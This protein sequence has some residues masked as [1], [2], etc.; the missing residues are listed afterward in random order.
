MFTLTLVPLTETFYSQRMFDPTLGSSGYLCLQR[1]FTPALCSLGSLS[2]DF[3]F[4]ESVHSH[5]R[6]SGR[7]I[8]VTVT[9]HFFFRLF[10]FFGQR[11]SVYKDCSVPL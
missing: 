1:L 5:F 4:T 11:H 3:E 9:F 6:F 10:K 8:R 2:R 7:D